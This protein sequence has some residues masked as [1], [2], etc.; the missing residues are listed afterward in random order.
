MTCFEIRPNHSLDST[1]SALFYGS[2]VVVG[3]AIALFFAL[4]GFWPVLPFAGLELGALLFCVHKVNQRARDRDWIE[5]DDN[6]VTVRRERD[7]SE[8]VRQFNR[9]WTNVRLEPSLGRL[10]LAI[11]A[12]NQW[13]TIG[14]F[15]TD[16]E[17]KGLGQRLRQVLHA[18]AKQ[19]N[20]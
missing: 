12:S 16:A 19:S 11:G 15:L 14:E 7:G 3:G 8:R 2:L 4:Q 10:R 5:I 1:S 18:P 20:D 6:T 17:R 13:C 9:A